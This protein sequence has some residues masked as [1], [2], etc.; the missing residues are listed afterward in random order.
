[1]LASMFYHYAFMIL[2]GKYLVLLVDR[3]HEC[4]SRWQDLVDKDENGFLRRELN[5]LA[6]NIDKL[7]DGEV[8][9][10]QVF[11]LVDSS[12]IRFFNLLTNHLDADSFIRLPSLQEKQV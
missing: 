2:G 9:R 10:H 4:S 8:G 11:L 5:A 1:M 3:A 7:T 12:D 6:D